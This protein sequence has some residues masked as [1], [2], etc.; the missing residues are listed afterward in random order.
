MYVCIDSFLGLG[1]EAIKASMYKSICID[2]RKPYH[3]SIHQP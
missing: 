1:F 2:D 3:Y